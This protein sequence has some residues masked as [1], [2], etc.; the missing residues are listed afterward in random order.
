M[1]ILVLGATGFVGKHLVKALKQTNHEVFTASRSEGVDLKVYEQAEECLEKIKPDVIFNCAAHTGSLHYVTANAADVL[2]DNL[3]IALNMYRAVSKACPKATIINP[4]SN[5]SYPGE[6]NVQVESE[7]LDGPVHESVFSYGNAKRFIY[8]LAK[9]YEK[10][11]GIKSILFLVPN[12]FGPGDAID[13]NKTHALNG[14][15]IRMIRAKRNGDKEFEIWGTGKPIREW[16]YIDDVV[17]ILEE[18]MTT[19]FDLTYPTN[20]AQGKGYSIKESAELI[21]KAVKFPG[22]LTF[23]TSYQDGA[24]VKILDDKKFRETFPNYKFSDHQKGIEETV[25]YYESVL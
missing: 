13:P 15:I 17:K 23:N 6:V 7:W 20:L 16:A 25:K 3:Q 12:T 4:L 24:M 10:Q 11:Y 9:C 21:A 14:M 8:V 19:T 1:K 22:K 18:G 2:H 5:C